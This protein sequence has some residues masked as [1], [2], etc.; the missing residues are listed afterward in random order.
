MGGVEAEENRWVPRH[1]GPKALSLSTLSFLDIY[2]QKKLL[3]RAEGSGR[4][5]GLGSA[6]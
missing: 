4:R 2:F 1:P 3:K 6:V 5:G